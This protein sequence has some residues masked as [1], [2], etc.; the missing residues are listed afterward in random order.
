[1]FHAERGLIELTGATGEW[2]WAFTCPKPECGCR[3][4]IVLSAVGDRE[5]LL[6]RGRPVADAWLTNGRYAQAALDLEGVT[7]FA[8]NLDTLEV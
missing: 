5:A 7:A 4:A 1:M 6:E 8:V 3:T 2:I